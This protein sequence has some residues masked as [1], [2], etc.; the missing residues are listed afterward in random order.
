MRKSDEEAIKKLI[1][2]LPQ[3]KSENEQAQSI[4]PIVDRVNTEGAKAEYA[5]QA[6]NVVESTSAALRDYKEKLSMTSSALSAAVCINTMFWVGTCFA[7]EALPPVSIWY[8]ARRARERVVAADQSDQLGEPGGAKFTYL[9]NDYRV[10]QQTETALKAKLTDAGQLLEL[11]GARGV[12][13][14]ARYVGRPNRPDHWAP[15]SNSAPRRR[16]SHLVGQGSG[17]VEVLVV[18]MSQKGW[19]NGGVAKGQEYVKGATR[20][21]WVT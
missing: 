10:D 14:E 4:V 16:R 12:L 21:Y 11:S 18:N 2:A 1:A 15:Q 13:L 7:A 6:L 5:A 3:F 19:E 8:P 17:P 9:I 20:D